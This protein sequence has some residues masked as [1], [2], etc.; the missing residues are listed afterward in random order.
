[1]SILRK[2]LVV[3]A[4]VIGCGLIISVGFLSIMSR[5]PADLKGKISNPRI[6]S[7]LVDWLCRNETEISHLLEARKLDYT[8]GGP[9][10]GPVH[11]P[12]DWTVLGFSPDQAQVRVIGA[13]GSD[14]VALYFRRSGGEGILVARKDNFGVSPSRLALIRG[15]LAVYFDS[16]GPE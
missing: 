5:V 7:Y 12:F 3:F 1:M 10:V 9:G 14:W 11:L 13:P 16:R 4:A 8:T 2:I 15:R 6:E